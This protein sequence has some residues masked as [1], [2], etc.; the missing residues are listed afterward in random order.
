VIDL[1]P[2]LD[3]LL[4]PRYWWTIDTYAFCE[5]GRN[6][7]NHKLTIIPGQDLVFGISF[8]DLCKQ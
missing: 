4:L 1:E 7:V 3:S 8:G 6:G 2:R 5:F